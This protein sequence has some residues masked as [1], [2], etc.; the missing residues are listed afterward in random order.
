MSLG[1]HPFITRGPG[2]RRQLLLFCFFNSRSIGSDLTRHCYRGSET[3]TLLDQ[4]GRLRRTREL[5][6]GS[7]CSL[8]R[9]VACCVGRFHCSW[10]RAQWP[11]VR[12]STRPSETA[13]R[14]YC[15]YVYVSTY[16]SDHSCS[17][18]TQ[19][20][21]NPLTVMTVIHST[22]TLSPPEEFYGSCSTIIF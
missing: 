12:Y 11:H 10:H 16:R 7:S 5:K 2:R 15:I 13:E 20:K 14:P 22:S 18:S 17:G 8:D 19:T 6:L 9:P 21:P 4:S 3:L 1:T